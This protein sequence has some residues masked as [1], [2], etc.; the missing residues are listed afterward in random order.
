MRE[1]MEMIFT[2]DEINRIVEGLQENADMITVDLHGLKVKD[3]R[4]FLQNLMAIGQG[5]QDICVIHGYNHGTAIK[6]MIYRD[7]SSKR[8]VNK[9]GVKGNC[10]RTMLKMHAE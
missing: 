2:K 3:A 1:K 9:T 8:L 6:E 7:L 5:R 10:G 4:R